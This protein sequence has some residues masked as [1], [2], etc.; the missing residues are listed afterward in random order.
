VLVKTDKGI[1]ERNMYSPQ[2]QSSVYK[3]FVE[4]YQSLK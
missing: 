4:L 1:I 2:K 3:N